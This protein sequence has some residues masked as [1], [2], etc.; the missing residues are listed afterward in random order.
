MKAIMVMFDSLNRRFLSPYGCDWTHTPNFK[1]L[2]ERTAA[3]DNCYVGSMPCMPAR[4]EIHAGRYNLLHRSWGPIEP[5]DDSMPEILKGAGVHTHLV[6]DHYHY[7]EE[8]GCTY[9]TR[10][11]TWEFA[12]GQEG[13][14]WIG[15]VRDPEIP[16][17]I[18]ADRTGSRMWRQDWVNRA[19]MTREQL[20]PQAKTFGGGIEF[21]RRNRDA[22]NWLLHIE[23]FDPHEPFF[24]QQHYKDLYPHD[25]DGPHFDWPPYRYVEETRDQVDHCR[26]EYAALVSMCDAWLGKLLD[27]MDELDLWDETMLIVNTDHGFLLGEHDSWAKCWCPWFDEKART[28]LFVWDPRCGVAGQRRASLVQTI[29]LAPTLLEYFGLEPT[30]DMQGS[31]LA[32]T[33]ADDTP[34]REAGLYGIF[35]GQLNVTDGRY[36]YFRAPVTTENQPLFEYTH[37]PTH[38][39]HTFSVEEMRGA[40]LAGPFAFTKGCGLMKIPVPPGRRQADPRMQRNWLFDTHADPHQDAPLDD[41]AVERR[42]LDHMVRLMRESDAPDEQYERLGLKR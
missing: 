28:P 29:D 42:M 13:D 7:W 40:T 24:T 23:T 41:P 27:T 26:Y 2:A 18:P 38:M 6:S 8:G 25:Y 20:Q 1:R 10:Y 31:P 17:A 19:H 35:G 39:T 36:T 34:V 9:H 16:P 32:Q 14:P 5:F 15:Q 37:M 11:S 33:V 21:L 4:R 3:F 12:R 30:A 22:D